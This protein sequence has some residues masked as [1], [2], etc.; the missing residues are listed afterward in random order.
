MIPEKIV[1]FVKDIINEKVIDGKIEN[2][3]YDDEWNYKSAQSIDN[4]DDPG[5][6]F[7]KI[8]Y[9]ISVFIHSS[10]D[11]TKL[12]YICDSYEINE[13]IANG[14]Y[15]YYL[16][17]IDSIPSCYMIYMNP[18]HV[19][20]FPIR[21]ILYTSEF[22]YHISSD[23]KIIYVY[24]VNKDIL[25]KLDINNPYRVNDVKEFLYNTDRPLIPKNMIARYIKDLDEGNLW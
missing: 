12:Q 18:S 23:D 14:D 7:Q 1:N 17:T 16:I 20:A 13:D 15:E 9:E 6:Y 5:L 22:Q 19:M 2:I 24:P 25:N 3:F 11:H 21:I 10:E 4:N 8:I